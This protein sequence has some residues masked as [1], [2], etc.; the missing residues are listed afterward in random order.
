MINI[1]VY[2]LYRT[3]ENYLNFFTKQ[4]CGTINNNIYKNT[5]RSPKNIYNLK[6]KYFSSIIYIDKNHP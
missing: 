1:P 4:I 3:H 2:I 6:N 5:S